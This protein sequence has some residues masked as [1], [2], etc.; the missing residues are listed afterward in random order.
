VLFVTVVVNLSC[1]LERNLHE[2][3]CG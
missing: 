2:T 1:R 3:I